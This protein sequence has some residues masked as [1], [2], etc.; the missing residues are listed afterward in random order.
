MDSPFETTLSRE[1]AYYTLSLIFAISAPFY[2]IPRGRSSFHFVTDV[3]DIFSDEQ[4]GY[5]IT[6]ATISCILI[7]VLSL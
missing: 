1:I 3:G 2:T 7:F 4:Q 5:L 6:R